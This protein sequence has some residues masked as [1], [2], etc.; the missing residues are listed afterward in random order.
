MAVISNSLVDSNGN[1]VV[2]VLPKL[3]EGNDQNQ[4]FG[5]LLGS[6]VFQMRDIQL[7]TFLGTNILLG[8][9]YPI[10]GESKVFPVEAA[11]K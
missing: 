5:C 6:K 4:Y 10:D 11:R 9:Q 1:L 3:K 2:C 8:P 7:S